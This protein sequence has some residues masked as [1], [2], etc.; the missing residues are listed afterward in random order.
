MIRERSVFDRP[1][2]RSDLISRSSETDDSPA[3]ILATRDWLDLRSLARS[4]W[5]RRRRCRTSRR[6]VASRSFNS[7]Y[8]ASSPDNPRNSG[9]LPNFQPRASRRFRFRSSTIV[10]PQ[11][12]LTRLDDACGRCPGLLA[13]H[14]RDHDAVR[15][16]PA[17]YSPDHVGILDPQ[18]SAARTN[19]RRRSSVWHAERFP[20][21]K[22]AKQI[23]CFQPR[24]P[25]EGR[26]P[27]FAVKPDEGFVTRLIRSI[28][29]QIRHT[30]KFHHVVL[31][32]MP[33]VFDT[34]DYTTT[35]SMR[36]MSILRYAVSVLDLV[37]KPCK[38]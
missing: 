37:R 17:D 31:R 33:P 23:S 22:P 12:A 3:S 14:R 4:P 8:A 28:L 30:D 10:V 11:S 18:F 35:V 36:E 2:T 34:P 20:L 7:M 15:V 19:G 29:C 25:R 5:V 32:E 6:L 9:T 21:L 1:S 27:D 38:S 24:S 16:G 26:R 13:E